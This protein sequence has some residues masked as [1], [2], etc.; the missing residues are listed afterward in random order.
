MR[1]R[2]IW[3]AVAGAAVGIPAFGT[4]MLGTAANFAVLG[5]SGGVTDS[6]T[7]Y[8]TGDLGL[9]P[10]GAITGGG[11]INFISGSTH[12]GDTAASDA[13]AAALS[14]YNTLNLMGPGTNLTG[15]D[16]G[17]VATLT[18]GVYSYSGLANLTGALT[19]NFQNLSNTDIIVLIGG[20]LNTTA[21]SS[22]SIQNLGSNDDVYW[23]V[24]GYANLGASTAFVG[25]IIANS[26]VTMGDLATDSCGSVIS[27]TGGEGAVTL[28]NNTIASCGASLAPEP[29]TAGL[30][31]AGC[32]LAVLAQRK[33][34]FRKSS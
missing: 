26:Y 12:N 34:R 28:S 20:Y 3:L 31:G 14:A 29:G 8:L 7:N 13:Q 18:H 1:Q 16:L 15:Q 11:T 30:V 33:L 9:S 32:L 27:L 5:N 22:V 21:S 2:L 6:G 10:T 25:N 4:Q 23:V 17:T 19:L 24:G